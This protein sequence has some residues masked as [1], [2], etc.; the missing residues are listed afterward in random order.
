MLFSHSFHLSSLPVFALVLTAC[1]LASTFLLLLQEITSE[2][3][4][5][6]VLW[7][8]EV[9]T[10][11]RLS[12]EESD[13]L[14]RDLESFI[15]SELGQPK[16]IERLW[17]F[18][19]RR[20][21]P[22][23]ASRVR[24]QVNLL[25]ELIYQLRIH[26]FESKPWVTKG[27]QVHLQGLAEITA[28][29]ATLR[30]AL[31]S[32]F[33]AMRQSRALEQ[34]RTLVPP[35]HDDEDEDDDEDAEHEYV[36]I[37]E[38][39]S[40]FDRAILS[41]VV[42]HGVV[43]PSPT[44]ISKEDFYDVY[45]PLL[46]VA[47]HEVLLTTLR[48]AP[49]LPLPSLMHAAAEGYDEAMT[50]HSDTIAIAGLGRSAATAA[51]VAGSRGVSA[52]IAA[53]AAVSASSQRSL[54]GSFGPSVLMGGGGSSNSG[55]LTIPGSLL[56]ISADGLA[57]EASYE[58]E[59]LALGSV[60]V[61]NTR[62]AHLVTRVSDNTSIAVHVASAEAVDAAA[63]EAAVAALDDG[64]DAEGITPAAAAAATAAKMAASVGSAATGPQG[65]GFEGVV[66]EV[67][68]AASKL[69][70]SRLERETAA[71]KAYDDRYVSRHPINSLRAGM[72]S[73]DQEQALRGSGT[74][75]YTQE[76][77]VNNV[78]S[79][80]AVTKEQ[81][82]EVY[83]PV[84]TTTGIAAI[85]PASA[86]S[87]S[88]AAGPAPSSGSAAGADLGG[89]AVI[90]QLRRALIVGPGGSDLL[91]HL[92][93]LSAHAPFLT[94]P[95]L[96]PPAAPL[97]NLRVSVS[98][99]VP[100]SLAPLDPRFRPLELPTSPALIRVAATLYRGLWERRERA[101]V[102][103]L[104]HGVPTRAAGSAGA[105]GSKLPGSRRGS[106]V[107]GI[108]SG[109]IDGSGSGSGSRRGSLSG[110]I[111]GG[112]GSRSNSIRR[113]SIRSGSLPGTGSRSNS[114]SSDAGGPDGAGAGGDGAGGES[115]LSVD[116]ITAPS[117]ANDP[118]VAPALSFDP[119]LF[120][121]VSAA[122]ILPGGR[123]EWATLTEPR[124]LAAV[125]GAHGG[126]EFALPLHTRFSA[127]PNPLAPGA[128]GRGGITVHKVDP[129]AVGNAA[130]A[131]NLAV[132]GES[133]LTAP[134]AGTTLRIGM[135]GAHGDGVLI[136]LSA[137]GDG[138]IESEVAPPGSETAAGALS[139]RA[140]ES[141]NV[142]APPTNAGA[143]TGS[144]VVA[145]SHVAVA[146]T[147]LPDTTQDDAKIAS[148]FPRSSDAPLGLTT[149]AAYATATAHAYESHLPEG[150]PSIRIAVHVVRLTRR[151]D[152]VGRDEAAAAGLAAVGQH[153]EMGLGSALAAALDDA[154]AAGSSGKADAADGV[155]VSEE[156]DAEDADGGTVL[157]PEAKAA[158]AAHGKTKMEG[159]V[160]AATAVTLAS[161]AAKGFQDHSDSSLLVDPEELTL[162]F[163]GTL[164][165]TPV[166]PLGAVIN[167]ATVGKALNSR[168]NGKSDYD[169]DM[170]CISS[171]V[172]LSQLMSMP[173]FAPAATPLAGSRAAKAAEHAAAGADMTWD[174]ND[175]AAAAAAATA[176]AAG[177]SPAEV[178]AAA[179][180]A[181]T[182]GAR[183]TA[184]A[185]AAQEQNLAQ[186]ADDLSAAFYTRL[187]RPSPSACLTA[188]S[189]TLTLTPVPC[190]RAELEIASAY[191]SAARKATSSDEPALAELLSSVLASE[192]VFPCPPPPIEFTSSVGSAMMSMPTVGGSGAA[193]SAVTPAPDTSGIVGVM[194]MHWSNPSAVGLT[195]RAAEVA[196]VHNPTNHNYTPGADADAGVAAGARE[197][198]SLAQLASRVD[199]EALAW[200]SYHATASALVTK[201]ALQRIRLGVSHQGAEQVGLTKLIHARTRQV[202]W[203]VRQKELRKQERLAVAAALV[204][205]ERGLPAPGEAAADKEEEDAEDEAKEDG[206]SDDKKGDKAS[207][208]GGKKS[209]RRP[210]NYI[211]PLV[212]TVM[213]EEAA[214]LLASVRQFARDVAEDAKDFGT[215]AV[216][217]VPGTD[218]RVPLID[219]AS[220]ELL[221]DVRLRTKRQWALR[222]K[223]VRDCTAFE[224][225][226]SITTLGEVVA[227]VAKGDLLANEVDS[228]SEN[229]AKKL[230]EALEV[231]AEEAKEA[232]KAEV[233]RRAVKDHEDQ[234]KA[235][236]KQE[237]EEIAAEGGVKSLF[238]LGSL[239]SSVLPKDEEVAEVKPD[240]LALQTAVEEMRERARMRAYDAWQK[241]NTPSSADPYAI[242][243]DVLVT[244]FAEDS[245]LPPPEEIPEPED[246]GPNYVLSLV[247][248]D[249]LSSQGVFTPVPDKVAEKDAS[250]GG[251]RPRSRVRPLPR[252]GSKAIAAA[253]TADDLRL[254]PG[255]ASDEDA[256]EE[257]SESEPEEAWEK[258]TPAMKA[259]I[260]LA[261]QSKFK[262][263]DDMA[264]TDPS[265]VE[266]AR[267]AFGEAA[268]LEELDRLYA[269][270]WVELVETINAKG[271]SEKAAFEA[272]IAEAEATAAERNAA[273]RAEA[274]THRAQATL[275]GRKGMEARRKIAQLEA[276]LV[277]VDHET[278]RRS[279]GKGSRLKLSTVGRRIA[280]ERKRLQEEGLF[281]SD[282]AMNGPARATPILLLEVRQARLRAKAAAIKTGP[283]D[284]ELDPTAEKRKE[285]LL[286]KADALAE[287]AKKLISQ[288]PPQPL[289][290][291]FQVSPSLSKDTDDMYAEPTTALVSAETSPAAD[292][293]PA[294]YGNDQDDDSEK[295]NGAY[296]S[297]AG[298]AAAAAL[299]A[300][301]APSGAATTGDS[302]PLSLRSSATLP[303]GAATGAFSVSAAVGEQIAWQYADLWGR[304]ASEAPETR[305]ARKRAV[306]EARA[307]AAA[308]ARAIHRPA[309]TGSAAAQAIAAVAAG[310]APTAAP[311]DTLMLNSAWADEMA[312]A[313]AVLARPE[314]RPRKYGRSGGA[315]MLPPP[316]LSASSIFSFTDISEEPKEEEEE[317]DVAEP[318]TL[319]DLIE[320]ADAPVVAQPVALAEEDESAQ[321]VAQEKEFDPF[322]A[323][324]KAAAQA[325]TMKVVK[326]R[327][328]RS[329]KEEAARAKA[330]AT[331]AEL[332]A[333]SEDDN[334]EQP[335]A[336]AE[337]RDT[338]V[339]PLPPAS[340]APPMRPPPRPPTPAPPRSSS[341]V[342]S[343]SPEAS[344]LVHP[345]AGGEDPAEGD[346]ATDDV[347]HAGEEGDVE[348]DAAEGREED[349][350]PKPWYARAVSAVTGKD[351]VDVFV[352]FDDFDPSSSST[353]ASNSSGDEEE[354][355]V[356]V[357]YD[358]EV[359]VE[360]IDE[361]G[362]V[363]KKKVIKQRTKKELR[364]KAKKAKSGDEKKKDDDGCVVM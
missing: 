109:S 93:V 329:R 313:A 254:A 184:A 266:K 242:A 104:L 13:A 125:V 352:Y 61:A 41:Q 335:R 11:S 169:S 207:G 260:S 66:D 270:E 196:R 296:L 114:I 182:S 319:L 49:P 3:W 103:S 230:A 268:S 357:V 81:R 178:A 92:P 54:T 299:D 19:Q 213:T 156:D 359:E 4:R 60:T 214:K 205:H 116:F 130:T 210:N 216:M 203:Y 154:V 23:F 282:P 328:R 105:M 228:L 279:A 253:A 134:A 17:P 37:D 250:W 31:G 12:A 139:K 331:L 118:R 27:S 345:A 332:E 238:G 85:A 300:A 324:A 225:D 43:A 306:A 77:G 277:S 63:T 189:A 170:D 88:A 244:L 215:V 227:A 147:D 294:P 129:S 278:V 223:A 321:L 25:T 99:L 150:S 79:R 258:L 289:S 149:P 292:D 127:I 140:K 122:V 20:S 32:V 339:V 162:D 195:L 349:A 193:G 305:V 291:L 273:L 2:V 181:S 241:M 290:H 39:L 192:T 155:V 73:A 175:H 115:S 362:R 45:L 33:A 360:T 301:P 6:L 237:K 34:I 310:R 70:A 67:S 172:P 44:T 173:S 263:D 124:P 343:H 271:E 303:P 94:V 107:A 226:P 48:R 24:E 212:A 57:Y 317:E 86:L 148:V 280:A 102:T 132:A 133:A 152:A 361:E 304:N 240:Y 209:T 76:Y 55:A 138:S 123:R 96:L 62:V 119:S 137:R 95:A 262:E 269:T 354:E 312:S 346:A 113:G 145:G 218:P 261:R 84:I 276:Q 311:I 21:A 177:K 255:D 252:N 80:S 5:F 29:Y 364:K 56:A 135:G 143:G 47:M 68:A 333:E 120:A 232:A 217:Y 187:S 323:A 322:A 108:G 307:S 318:S 281:T 128:D 267:K 16:M 14:V 40:E 247:V 153:S 325:Q 141:G 28:T 275:S 224:A 164:G 157:S 286:K 185:S 161:L 336:A 75:N 285:A 69:V 7:W 35:E 342:S 337:P 316:S 98:G 71:R 146:T 15:A 341:P 239:I 165:A 245:P 249:R 100:H 353:S 199:W 168:R 58:P 298:I 188:G 211:Q 272:A 136:G 320:V 1:P 160:A 344:P 18:Y 283:E 326:R 293:E 90:S 46:T 234:E 50:G 287:E 204:A 200:A 42:Q 257:E 121:I 256:A 22:K 327:M 144:L 82:F 176:L 52:A 183:A 330:L 72:Y 65:Q 206:G 131:G 243:P 274:D 78:I 51:T 10:Y 53:A 348:G 158:K 233:T 83:S 236:R 314:R 229:D 208:E 126:V 338:V 363:I 221:H 358:E 356:E 347:A 112:S 202:A 295:V 151:S 248:R 36:E 309:P 297:L 26:A 231:A 191:P 219:A 167:P 106:F 166:L 350:E 259:A 110:S 235:R 163:V 198:P 284:L 174:V 251:G 8:D 246:D 64:V 334:E 194:G 302:A 351:K 101:L 308:Q 315:I 171:K 111:G 97:F 89:S 159:P 9:S 190:A 197:P 74:Y 117:N 265:L 288:Q 264:P 355:E 222:E 38:G 91:S 87:S 59:R 142:F 340:T 201:S 179:R 30:A 186:S 180:A 220:G